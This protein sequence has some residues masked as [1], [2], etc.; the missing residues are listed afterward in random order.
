MPGFARACNRQKGD[1]EAALK[2]VEQFLQLA[3]EANDQPQIALGHTE[4][5]S[6]LELQE[7]FA[8]ALDHFKQAHAIYKSQGVERSIAYNLQSRGNVLWQLGRYQD[9]PTVFFDALKK[10][11]GSRRQEAVRDESG[12]RLREE[13]GVKKHFRVP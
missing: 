10:C 8:V 5:A 1:Y 2:G 13:A 3:Q 6:V 4:L 11:D 9:A 12:F 7:K